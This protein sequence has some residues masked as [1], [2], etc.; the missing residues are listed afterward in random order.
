MAQIGQVLCEKSIA[1]QRLQIDHGVKNNCKP[2][3]F[4]ESIQ[5]FILKGNFL[6]YLQ[7]QTKPQDG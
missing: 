2:I 1:Y 4:M 6:W 7:N 3:K 5:P